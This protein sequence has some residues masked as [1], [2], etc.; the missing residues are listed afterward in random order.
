L[1]HGLLF[2]T[3][4]A[5][6]H[7]PVQAQLPALTGQARK[8]IFQER[9]FV[10]TGAGCAKKLLHRTLVDPN[11]LTLDRSTDR[12]RAGRWDSALLR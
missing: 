1:R 4:L 10:L 12:R 11:N 9:R 6:L 2:T 3:R 5:L 7:Q 8:I